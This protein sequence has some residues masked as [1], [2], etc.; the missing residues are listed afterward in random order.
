MVGARGRW[1]EGGHLNA[2][3]VVVPVVDE[4]SN[5]VVVPDV[6]VQMAVGVVVLELVACVLVAVSVWSCGGACA[7]RRSDRAFCRCAQS[8]FV[9][10]SRS[11]CSMRGSSRG[12]VVGRKAFVTAIQ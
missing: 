12:T 8:S 5:I 9:A 3:A 10:S 2:L 1:W 7:R 6:L 11:V 4:V